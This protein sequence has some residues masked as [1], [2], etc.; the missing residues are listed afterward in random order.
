MK[1]LKSFCK[2]FLA[3]YS[4]AISAPPYSY[5]QLLQH[6]PEQREIL[7][8]G[9]L[10]HLL[11]IYNSETTGSNEPSDTI[12]HL[13]HDIPSSVRTTTLQLK[14][15]YLRAYS[16]IQS[17]NWFQMQLKDD[18]GFP[19]VSASILEQK[20]GQR[21]A[22]GLLYWNAPDGYKNPVPAPVL[23]KLRDTLFTILKVSRYTLRDGSYDTELFH[24]FESS[25]PLRVLGA[26]MHG[27]TYYEA[28]GGF[29]PL[30]E[31]QTDL[32]KYRNAQ[33][34]LYNLPFETIC[35]DYASTP[36]IEE[37]RGKFAPN[38]RFGEI[39]L[40]LYKDSRDNNA[41]SFKILKWLD[42]HCLSSYTPQSVQYQDIRAAQ[43]LII[44]TEDFYKD[45]EL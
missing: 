2:L 31:D 24:N 5:L 10:G 16:E 22:H 25:L 17:K 29:R 45:Y 34:L 14:L 1:L 21:H 20:T 15:G 36:E 39:V 27:N 19:V 35:K 8:R 12:E 37:L 4:G 40:K 28:K 11:G 13:I 9:L 6:A 41:G 26:Y 3:L 44:N 33:N 18:S 23:I 7:R 32:E 43:E 42:K 30:I 38:S